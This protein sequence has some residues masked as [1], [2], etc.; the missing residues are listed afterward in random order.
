MQYFHNAIAT[1][2]PQLL[3]CVGVARRRHCGL[4]KDLQIT[5]DNISILRIQGGY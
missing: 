3:L 1:I 5:P 4:H 2:S